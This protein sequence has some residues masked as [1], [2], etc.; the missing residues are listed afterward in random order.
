MTQ[1]EKWQGKVAVPSAEPQPG[2]QQ[3]VRAG[4]GIML[5]PAQPN[6]QVEIF[7]LECV[8]KHREHATTV[9]RKRKN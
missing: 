8:Y 5:Q 1:D 9:N 6:G 2:P 4:I 3:V 7:E